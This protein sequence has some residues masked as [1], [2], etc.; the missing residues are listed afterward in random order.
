[1]SQVNSTTG[2]KY[3]NVYKN[4]EY[5]YYLVDIRQKGQRFKKYYDLNFE[6][7]LKAIKFINETLEYLDGIE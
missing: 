6:G 4:K 2:I 7:M 1:M 5:S 3:L